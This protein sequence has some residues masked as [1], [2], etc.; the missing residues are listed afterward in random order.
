MAWRWERAWTES[1][2]QLYCF[3]CHPNI[4]TAHRY[5]TKFQ[6]TLL[7]VIQD[8][9]T[10]T[11]MYT[12]CLFHEW[13]GKK[14]FRRHLPTISLVCLKDSKDVGEGGPAFS[15]AQEAAIVNLIL[16]NNSI[17]QR[18]IQR[19]I[20]TD[21]TVF[22]NIQQV[23]LSA[24][25]CVLRVLL[26]AHEAAPHGACREILPEN[27]KKKKIGETSMWEE[28]QGSTTARSIQSGVVSQRAGLHRGDE[29]LS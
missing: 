6:F 5:V 9:T 17:K 26:S 11:V 3:L 24:S 19:G 18:E 28:V 21:N 16:A 22:N 10:Q 1:P 20:M 12:S 14:T 13:E 29:L 25:D 4:Q 27:K 2:V 15:A 8:T 23:S 7:L